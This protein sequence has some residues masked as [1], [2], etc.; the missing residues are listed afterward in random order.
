MP[1]TDSIII[2]FCVV[3]CK[4]KSGKA[5]DSLFIIIGMFY[6]DDT[7]VT[8]KNVHVHSHDLC[9]SC[10]YPGDIQHMMHCIDDIGVLMWL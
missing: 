5:A 9:H 3:L 8:S 10:R 4:V 1:A 6:D 7:T 2:I